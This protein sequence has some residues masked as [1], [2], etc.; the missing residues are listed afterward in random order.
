MDKLNEMLKKLTCLLLLA[1]LFLLACNDEKSSSESA[2][3]STVVPQVKVPRFD[4]DSSLSY[5]E[6]QVAFGP[7][8][9][10]TKTHQAAK[11]WFVKKFEQLGAKVIQQEFKATA[12]TGTVLHGTN[13]IAAYQPE[14]K[15]RILLAAHWD[16][17]PF[18]D[19]ESKVEDQKKAVLGADDGASGVA[20]LIEIARQLNAQPVDIGVDLILFDAEDY[21]K[22]GEDGT[23]ESWCLGSQ[24]WAASPHQVGYKAKFGILLDMVG[25]ENARFTK[26]GTSMTYAPTIMDKVWKIAKNRGYGNYFVDIK[27]RELIDDHL[28]INEIAGIPTIDIINRPI[29]SKTGFGH[30]WH[31]LHDDLSII[32][33]RTLRAVG[34]TVLEVVYRLDVGQF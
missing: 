6:K 7:R 24:Y 11:A 16:T 29:E 28:F 2:T 23:A 26:E 1:G 30:Y 18:A 22:G 19:Q 32:D 33:K 4:R 3:S 14:A 27:T 31:T 5:L 25:A 17:R 10:N 9:P 8:V 15:K 13:I 21:G 12:Y 20:V 34:Q